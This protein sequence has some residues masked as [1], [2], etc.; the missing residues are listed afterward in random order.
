MKSNKTSTVCGLQPGR[1]AL[2]LGVGIAMAVALKD[3]A[4]GTAIGAAIALS[5]QIARC[6][7]PE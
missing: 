5:F 2:G 6:R 4:V 7:R 3:V 1:F